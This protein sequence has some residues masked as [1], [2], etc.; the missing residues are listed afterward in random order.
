MET[1]MPEEWRAAG[2]EAENTEH[3]RGWSYRRDTRRMV[4]TLDT[5]HA[6]LEEIRVSLK[7]LSKDDG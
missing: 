1:M 6:V 2:A 4:K 3:P 5:Y 7:R